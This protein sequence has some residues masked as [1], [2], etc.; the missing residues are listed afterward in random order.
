MDALPLKN[1]WLLP[2]LGAMV[3][4]GAW[5]FLPKLAL[6]T[7][8]IS[9]TIFYEAVGGLLISVVF[10]YVL[11]GRLDWNQRAL[12][13]TSVTSCLSIAAILSYYYAIKLGPVAVVSTMAAMYPVIALILARV[14]LKEQISRVQKIAVAMAAVSLVLLVH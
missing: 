1:N 4:W 5:A 7:L 11:R 13:I 9:S 6:K 12:A 10:L 3:L 2:S 14:F 8:S